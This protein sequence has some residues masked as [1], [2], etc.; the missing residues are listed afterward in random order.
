MI[1]NKRG[2]A[3]SEMWA[4]DTILFWILFGIALGFSIIFFN[5]TLAKDAAAQSK[6]NE[7][8]ESLNLMQRFFESPYCFIYNKEGLLLNNVIDIDK[9]TEERLNSCYKIADNTLP[10]FSITLNSETA[11]ISKVIKTK[12][13]ND[14]RE[15]EDRMPPKEVQIHSGDKIQNGEMIIEIQNAR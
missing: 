3:A 12:N 8:L 15:F 7:N 14:N 13:W 6:I 10:A 1:F 11:K 2:T 9:F 4:P 5:I